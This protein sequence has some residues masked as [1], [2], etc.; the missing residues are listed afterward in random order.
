MGRISFD[1]TYYL[2]EA[3][4]HSKPWNYRPH[5]RWGFLGEQVRFHNRVA[6][7]NR[8]EAKR[9][10]ERVNRWA[11]R[12]SKENPNPTFRATLRRNV[13]NTQVHPKAIA[14]CDTDLRCRCGVDP[15]QI[16]IL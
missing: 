15:A 16:T 5:D 3:C 9:N 1:N 11:D 10:M 8:A 2:D 12:C 6:K 14:A 4:D 13:A 7:W